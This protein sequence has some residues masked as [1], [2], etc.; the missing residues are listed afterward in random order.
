ML[1]KGDVDYDNYPLTP[2]KYVE[3]TKDSAALAKVEAV[4]TENSS[5]SNFSYGFI[6][7]NMKTPLFRDRDVRMAMSMLIN[8][9][10][11]IEKFRFGMSEKATG[12]FGNRNPSSSPDVKPVEFDPKGALALLEKTGWKMGPGGLSKVI[13]GKETPFVFT[14]IHAHPDAEKYF[15]IIKED[16]RKVGITMNIKYVE[17]T[18]FVKLL[19]E[20]KFEATSLNWAAGDLEPDP[21]QIFHS[22][23]IPAPGSNFVSYSNPEVDKLIDQARGTMDAKARLPLMRKIHEL[24]AADQPYSFLFNS[25]STLYGNT[26]RIKKPFGLTLKYD[27]ASET[28]LME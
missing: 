9:D 6:G 22:A 19:D 10:Q 7:W 24:I 18:S 26:K 23:S 13:D 3:L 4:K 14:L 16:M 15:T 8:R 28:W 17:W 21:K 20:R 11:M 27:V 5:P 1:K 2:E 25:K 12:P